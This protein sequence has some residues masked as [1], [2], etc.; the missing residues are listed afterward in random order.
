MTDKPL[1]VAAAKILFFRLCVI[2]TTYFDECFSFYVMT[3][4]H[5]FHK[6]LSL[7]GRLFNHHVVALSEE[8][9]L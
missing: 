7:F 9:V 1:K 6:S 4:R 8:S 3:G 2:R 5:F